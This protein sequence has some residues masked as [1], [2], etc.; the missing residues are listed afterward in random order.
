MSE[1]GDFESD[2]EKLLAEDE[3]NRLAAEA[4]SFAYRFL[5]DRGVVIFDYRDPTTKQPLPKP[6]F[7]D[8][9]SVKEAIESIINY[10]EEVSN[11]IVK[12]TVVL[13]G[14]ALVKKAREL[15]VSDPDDKKKLQAQLMAE[16]LDQAYIELVDTVLE[17]EPLGPND[18]EI[19]REAVLE[20]TQKEL[21]RVVAS[22]EAEVKIQATLQLLRNKLAE[23]GVAIDNSYPVASMAIYGLLLIYLAQE[24]EK[25]F[26]QGRPVPSK[27]DDARKIL[28]TWGIDDPRWYQVIQQLFG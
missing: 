5:M 3:A 13:A 28:E 27:I 25:E 9:E 7:E 22:A 20:A 12:T 17:G 10:S 2:L 18:L 19:Y 23:A 24:G 4:T 1:T 16:G 21:R 6:S 14:V 26:N 8:E 15:K 11:N